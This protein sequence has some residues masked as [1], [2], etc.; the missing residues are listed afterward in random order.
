MWVTL[1]QTT[2]LQRRA[3]IATSRAPAH[4]GPTSFPLDSETHSLPYTRRETANPPAPSPRARFA[5]NP[6]IGPTREASSRLSRR[7]S[8]L[9]SRS[10]S[11]LIV[12]SFKTPSVDPVTAQGNSSLA[13]P[14]PSSSSASLLLPPLPPTSSKRSRTTSMVAP[15]H[16]PWSDHDYLNPEDASRQRKMVEVFDQLNFRQRA[17]S[18]SDFNTPDELHKRNAEAETY[19]VDQAT[20]LGSN[21]SHRPVFLTDQSALFPEKPLRHLSFLSSQSQSD[22]EALTSSNYE[23]LDFSDSSR[24]V[25]TIS[26]SGTSSSSSNFPSS[27]EQM[28]TDIDDYRENKL[29]TESNSR[30]DPL[31]SPVASASS[32]IKKQYYSGELGTRSDSDPLISPLEKLSSLSLTRPSIKGRQRSGTVLPPKKPQLILES[33]P[34]DSCIVLPIDSLLAKIENKSIK[35]PARPPRSNRRGAAGQPPD[36]LLPIATG[37]RKTDSQ[38]VD[39]PTEESTCSDTLKSH[40]TTKVRVED[41]GSVYASARS[42]PAPLPASAPPASQLK[43]TIIIS[44]KTEKELPHDRSPR[45]RSPNEGHPR[46]MVPPRPPSRSG[47]RPKSSGKNL[48]AP[49]DP[50]SRSKSPTSL[51]SNSGSDDEADDFESAEEGDDQ[52]WSAA[53]HH[54]SPSTPNTLEVESLTGERSPES[55]PHSHPPSTHELVERERSEKNVDADRSHKRRNTMSIIGA[56]PRSESYADSFLSSAPS[57][58]DTT[59]ELSF[60]QSYQSLRTSQSAPKYSQEQHSERAKNTASIPEIPYE[61]QTPRRASHLPP[62]KPDSSP[63]RHSMKSSAPGH[64]ANV[65]QAAPLSP[66]PA[67]PTSISPSKSPFDNIRISRTSSLEGL[68]ALRNPNGPSPQSPRKK[69]SVRSVHFR[70][71]SKILSFCAKDAGFDESSESSDGHLEPIPH[72]QG[73]HQAT[74]LRS[75]PQSPA[76]SNTKQTSPIAPSTW[77]NSMSKGTYANLLNTYGALEMRRQEL[78]WELCETEHSFAVGLRQVIEIFVFPLRTPEGAWI[79]GVPTEV[80]RLLD[81]LEDIVNLHSQMAFQAKNCCEYQT[82]ALGLVVHIS[83]VFLE[84]TPKLEVYQPYLIRFSEVTTAIEEMVTNVDSDFGEFVRMQSSLPECGRMSLTSFLLKPV[85]RLMKYPLFYK[86]LCDV[87]PPTHPDH[88]AT[89]CLFSA[90]DSMVRVLQEVKEREDEYEKLQKMES[91]VRGL[92]PGFKLAKRDRRLLAQGLLKRVQLPTRDIHQLSS[93]QGNPWALNPQ[94]TATNQS[95]SGSSPQSGYSSEHMGSAHSRNSYH[96]NWSQHSMAPSLSTGPQSA[97]SRRSSY[98]NR[99]NEPM[100]FLNYPSSPTNP[101]PPGSKEFYDWIA[102]SKPSGHPEDSKHYLRTRASGVWESQTDDRN[103]RKSLPASR[104]SRKPKESPVHVFVFSD[105][106]LLATRHSDGVRLIRSTKLQKKKKESPSYYSVLEDVGISRLMAV[107]DIS[108]ELEYPHL[109]K[110]DLL[111]F[112]ETNTTQYTIKSPVSVLLTFPDRL[113]GSSQLSTYETIQK[114]R[115]KWLAAFHQAL[116]SPELSLRSQ[117]DDLSDLLDPSNPAFQKIPIHA[118]ERQERNW[119]SARHRLVAKELEFSPDELA[120]EPSEMDS[121]SYNSN[122]FDSL[123]VEPSQVLSSVNQNRTLFLPHPHTENNSLLDQIKT[124]GLGLDFGF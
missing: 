1:E 100:S 119:W 63:Q 20:K 111:P 107:S 112:G 67:H 84:L 23:S 118:Q 74:A 7:K 76:P 91:R 26:S 16:T 10:P 11:Q 89:V 69:T 52:F 62:S 116:R 98:A 34:D 123:R 81:W 27:S 103:R 33:S 108:G 8:A 101:F 73:D 41:S 53:E 61:P 110:L 58:P 94:M 30:L 57:N 35:P 92:P 43:P 54:E 49:N 12:P 24:P 105:V 106:I 70:Q 15:E 37:Q 42:S 55:P 25:S 88:E 66:Y 46:A 5:E 97:N 79:S 71:L 47:A 9:K 104:A 18:M 4:H 80:A 75:H 122:S 120:S 32:L 31:P 36:P 22:D 93:A 113:P 77:K 95:H 115:F 14:G 13:N 3:S 72:Q 21:A 59:Q 44:S 102:L 117:A 28:S 17:H 121:S 6:I 99:E 60:E 48:G 38:M 78:I 29:F 86:Q 2:G 124:S 64:S 83:E 96:S 114:E 68:A 19:V 87:T 65:T 82:Q 51:A 56:F 45:E 50:Y 90:T 109:L 85:Q 40:L 39:I